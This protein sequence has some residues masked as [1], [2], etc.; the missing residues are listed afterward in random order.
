MASNFLFPSSDDVWTTLANPTPTRRFPKAQE[1]SPSASNPGHDPEDSLFERLT[2]GS[3]AGVAMAIVIGVVVVIILSAWFCCNCCGLRKRRNP[4]HN[5]P[6][7]TNVM[8]LHTM[9]NRVPPVPVATHP[10][11]EAPPPA[12]EEVVRP[13]HPRVMTDVPHTREEDAGVISD[14]KTPLSEIPFEDVVLDHAS[15]QSSSSR[16]FEQNHHGF[17]GDTRGHTNS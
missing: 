8:P 4:P 14:G 17:G 3:K 13:Q 6:R 7:V 11:G 9:Q 15:S 16:T 10:P 12:Y 2:S 5:N 1:T